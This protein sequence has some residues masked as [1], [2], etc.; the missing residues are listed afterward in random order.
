MINC[1]LVLQPGG[2][3]KGENEKTPVLFT[4]NRRKKAPA[5]CGLLN[6]ECGIKILKKIV[7][8]LLVPK[9]AIRNRFTHYLIIAI[10]KQLI[11]KL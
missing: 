5:D 1:V 10:Q 6:Y 2:I 4:E 11:S 3:L 7:I 8:Y 9:S